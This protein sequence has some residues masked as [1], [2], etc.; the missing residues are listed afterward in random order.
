MGLVSRQRMV[1]AERGQELLLGFSQED[2]GEARVGVLKNL[3]LEILNHFS[4]QVERRRLVVYYLD[5]G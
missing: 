4:Q 2:M 5:F 1:R 3:R